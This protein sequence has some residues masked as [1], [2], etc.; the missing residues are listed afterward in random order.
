MLKISGHT[1]E[2]CIN[3]EIFKYTHAVVADF[4]QACIDLD[5]RVIFNTDWLKFKSLVKTAVRKGLFQE[6]QEKKEMYNKVKNIN[7][8]GLKKPQPYL[9][10][11]KFEN[12]MSSMLFNLR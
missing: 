1:P 12:E 4:Q 11:Y 8:S 5:E 9:T 3:L 10:S 2:I 7:F 6:L